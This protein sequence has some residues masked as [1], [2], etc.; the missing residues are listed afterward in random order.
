[1]SE[2]LYKLPIETYKLDFVEKQEQ[3]IDAYCCSDVM[4]FT[5]REDN[6]PN[7]IIEAMALGI[8]TVAYDIGGCSDIIDN[9]K[10]GY[11][12]KQGDKA[13]FA[14]AI[15]RILNDESLRDRLYNS[16]L[17][18]VAAE[19]S[20]K[21]QA[22]GYGKLFEE[23]LAEDKLANHPSMSNEV[24]RQIYTR[25]L[26]VLT[27][28]IDTDKVA[29]YKYD[30]NAVKE[31]LDK[32]TRKNSLYYLSSPKQYAH[33][34]SAYDEQYG[35]SPD[36]FSYGRGLCNLLEDRGFE[37]SGPALEIGCG[38]GVLSM[39]VAKQNKF[40]LYIASDASPEFLDILHK[41]LGNAGI[42]DDRIR[43]A[44][45]DGD[46]L[47]GAPKYAFSMIVLKAT[48]HHIIDPEDFIR[49]ISELLAPNGVMVFHEPFWEGTVMLGIMAQA[50][51]DKRYNRV[52]RKCWKLLIAYLRRYMDTK[53]SIMS[54]LSKWVVVDS[55]FARLK[56][57]IDTMQA[58]SNR[59]IDKSTWEDKHVFRTADLIN[60]CNKLD[61]TVEFIPNSEF[62]DFDREAKRQSF[63][64]RKFIHTY[65]AKGMNYGEDFAAKF[66][67]DLPA[68]YDYLDK[69]SDNNNDP[70]FHGI[71]I[72]RKKR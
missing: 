58:A 28:F 6:L 39:G 12:V 14:D 29:D 43:L 63:T 67:E 37:F 48:L 8:P 19:Y 40:P 5:S 59:S 1:V 13:A 68:I 62:N 41:K 42:T 9:D 3:I 23:I 10:N 4:L 20:P 22:K 53:N 31:W 65:I 45:L 26:A 61:L 51:F 70:H 54:R 66:C 27:N 21:Q 64:Y 34:E 44:V 69:I 72:L 55:D 24:E 11:L 46:S 33:Q 49:S 15:A 25:R 50:L 57:L 35:I 60:W 16:C 38:T 47:L 18:K 17:K 36:D 30:L 56:L 71:F 52:Q 7:N 2:H 32:A